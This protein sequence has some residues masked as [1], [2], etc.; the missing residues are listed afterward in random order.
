MCRAKSLTA[1]IDILNEKSELPCVHIL[2]FK[3]HVRT[4]ILEIPKSQT[5]A[6]SNL[7]IFC[8]TPCFFQSGRLTDGTQ[9]E[10]F[11]V[12]SPVRGRKYKDQIS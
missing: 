5:A 6:L 8:N 4:H 10:I 11:E 3:V 7:K 12:D 1:W 9:M 2:I